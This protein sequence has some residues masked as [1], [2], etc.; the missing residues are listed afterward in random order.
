MELVWITHTHPEVC[1]TVAQLAQVAKTRCGA[2]HARGLNKANRCVKQDPRLGSFEGKLSF[3]GL[4]L[5][6]YSDGS[7]ANNADSSSQLG[8][9]ILLCGGQD[10]YCILQYKS[11]KS[12]R[13]VR[14]VLGAELYLFA[15]ALTAHSPSSTTLSACWREKSL[16][17]CSQTPNCRT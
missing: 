1:C 14:S 13:V 6:E 7:S 5:R 2:E 11:F 8:L 4:H 16:C 15:D 12:K 17:E 10:R 3:E 9:I